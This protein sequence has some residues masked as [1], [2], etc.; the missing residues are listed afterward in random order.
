MGR[1]AAS[2]LTRDIV[3]ICDVGEVDG[4]DFIAMGWCPDTP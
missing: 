3:T 4:V 1:R 2:A